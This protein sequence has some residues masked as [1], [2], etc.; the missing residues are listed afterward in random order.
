MYS[1]WLPHVAKVHL[2]YGESDVTPDGFIENVTE[3]L[4]E[5]ATKIKEK[6]F[7]LSL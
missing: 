4:H 3:C 5:G 6:L 7:S 2:Y 1:Y